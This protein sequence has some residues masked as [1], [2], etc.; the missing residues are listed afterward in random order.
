MEWGVPLTEAVSML[1]RQGHRRIGVA[2][3]SQPFLA[4]QMGRRQLEY[5]QNTLPDVELKAIT[6]SC[7]PDENYAQSLLDMVKASMDANG[8]LPYTALIVWGIEDGEK[9]RTQLLQLGLAVPSKLSVVL[10][11]RTD[12]ENEHA[13]FFTTVGYSVADQVECLYQAIQ[14]RWT[15]PAA[16]YGLKL[17]PLAT[18]MGA[19][20]ASPS[21]AASTSDQEFPP[22]GQPVVASH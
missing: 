19:S 2:S 21:L 20:T 6:I 1:Q 3:T 9:F 8:N 11:G 17:L 5:L 15:S 12:L 10:L 14:T 16:P 4:I 18:R 7:L 22:F 13:N